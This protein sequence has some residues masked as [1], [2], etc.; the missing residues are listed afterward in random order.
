VQNYSAILRRPRGMF[1]SGKDKG[2]MRSMVYNW[3]NDDL[4]LIVVTDF[5]R[6]LGIGDQ[7]Y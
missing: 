5:S 4:E 3:P 7:R 2:M 6:I 1:F